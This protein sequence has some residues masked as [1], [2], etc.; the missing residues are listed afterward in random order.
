V[1]KLEFSLAADG[2]AI[3]RVES[4]VDEDQAE[5]VAAVWRKFRLVEEGEA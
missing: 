5:K 2:V 1:R 4:F 3:L